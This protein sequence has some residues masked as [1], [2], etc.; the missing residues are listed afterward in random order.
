MK[1][2]LEI[3][4]KQ[5]RAETIPIERNRVF[6]LMPFRSE[7]NRVYGIIKD[8]LTKN[9]FICN[10]ADEISGSKPILNKILCEIMRS[11]YIIADLSDQ[12]PNV[13]YELGITHSFKDVQNV[14]L[15]KDRHTKAP[16]DITH[17]TYCEYDVDNSFA[18]R[19]AVMSFIE[20]GR[21]LSDFQEALDAKGIINVVSESKN[22]FVDVLQDTFRANL[23]QLTSLLL[24]DCGSIG[25]RAIANIFERFDALLRDQSRAG[26]PGIVEGLTKT[27]FASLASAGDFPA[28]REYVGRYMEERALY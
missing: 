18:L 27:Y 1:R 12:N 20:E 23:G 16:F 19:E 10:R 17:L 22:A 13:F 3:Y 21:S 9:G 4:P 11:R 6:V 2:D 8:E 5:F 15:I 25:D 7:Y 26:D 28:A 14:L 24:G